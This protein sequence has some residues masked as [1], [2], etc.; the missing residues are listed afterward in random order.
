MEQT[1]IGI[2]VAGIYD[3]NEEKAPLLQVWPYGADEPLVPT[4]E[5]DN[6]ICGGFVEGKQ[7]RATKFYIDFRDADW[8]KR[9][10]IGAQWRRMA[11]S[12]VLECA[13]TKLALAQSNSVFNAQYCGTR[14]RKRLLTRLLYKDAFGCLNVRMCPL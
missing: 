1:S 7:V 13:E 9:R 8:R 4:D 6:V 12:G 11:P 3:A 10:L 14:M 2:Q 5:I